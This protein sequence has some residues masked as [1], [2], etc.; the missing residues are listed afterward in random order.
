MREIWG[1]FYYYIE[2]SLIIY[3]K[4]TRHSKYELKMKQ[5]PTYIQGMLDMW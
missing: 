3:K 5:I 1:D 2:Y 4:N